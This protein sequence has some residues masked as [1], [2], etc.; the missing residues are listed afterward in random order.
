MYCIKN[1]ETLIDFAYKTL[2]E[3]G[4]ID[5]FIKDL[6]CCV[7]EFNKAYKSHIYWTKHFKSFSNPSDNKQAFANLVAKTE[8]SESSLYVEIMNRA[9]DQFDALSKGIVKYLEETKNEKLTKQVIKKIET[10]KNRF[11]A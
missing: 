1:P 7:K 6:D 9:K 3:H 5:R 11:V 10:R 2:I 8:N 4:A